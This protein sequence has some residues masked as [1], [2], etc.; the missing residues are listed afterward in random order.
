MSKYDESLTVLDDLRARVIYFSC[1]AEPKNILEISKLWNYK[2]STYF[3]QEKSREILNAMVSKG[4]I[5]VVEGSCLQ[6]NLDWVLER[7]RTTKFFEEINDLI[8][9]EIIVEKYEYEVTESQLEDP[10]FKEFCIEK[11]PELKGILSGIKIAGEEIDKFLLL[12]KNPG[13][14][15]VFLSPDVISELMYNRGELPR[16]PTELLFSLTVKT[17]E[18]VYFFKEGGM[19]DFPDP[20]FWFEIQSAFPLLL[21][22]L[23]VLTSESPADFRALTQRFKEVYEVLKGKFAIYVGRSEISAYHAAKFVEVMKL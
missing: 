5:S 23:K 16:N 15:K 2:T 11:K 4:L 13:F 12:W 1:L 3:Y 6:S 14:K 8:A 19:P 10:L 9:N 21:T 18:Q 22:K 17:C 7:K 20:N